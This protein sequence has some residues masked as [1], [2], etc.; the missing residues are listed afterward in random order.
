MRRHFP[1]IHILSTF[2]LLGSAGTVSAEVMLVPDAP[3]SCSP[4][5]PSA[6][7]EPADLQMLTC[8]IDKDVYSADNINLLYAAKSKL[9]GF[10]HGNS[11][12]WT[13]IVKAGEHTEILPV[14]PETSQASAV[15]MWVGKGL[16]ATFTVFISKGD[17]VSTY[18]H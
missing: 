15:S 6:G 10:V 7:S 16:P 13:W 12:R 18:A 5:Y 2:A 9:V 14:V 3:F 8:F 11:V 17:G 1:F 4:Q